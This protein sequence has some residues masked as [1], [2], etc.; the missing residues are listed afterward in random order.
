L[1]HEARVSG[2]ESLTFD[3]LKG[4]D[5]M[6]PM[7]RLLERASPAVDEFRDAVEGYTADDAK[8]ELSR[9]TA[10]TK[11]KA[12]GAASGEGSAKRSKAAVD[13]GDIDWEAELKAGS[14][15]KR[16]VAQLKAACAARGLAKSGKK[17]DL[18]ERLTA[19]LLSAA[20]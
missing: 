1:E 18:V 6:H 8:A 7:Q 19:C 13:E 5:E 17:Q 16:T 10:A 15:K 12:T 2:K 3:D 14:L 11:R 9:K 4:M 20:R